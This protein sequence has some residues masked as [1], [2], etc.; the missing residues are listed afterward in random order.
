MTTKI[1]LIR[2]AEAEGNWRRTFQGH[3][4]GEISEKGRRQLE[5]LAERFRDIPL[6]AV[7]SSPLRR[8]VATAQAVNH[9]GLPII[10][11]DRLM[12]INGG[13][14]EGLRF[15]ELSEHFPSEHENWRLAPHLFTAPNGE[16]MASVYARMREVMGEIARNNA[17]KT[18][19][20]A[21]HGCAIRNYQCFALGLGLP[22]IGEVTWCDNTA[23]TLLEYGEDFT[24]R[25]VALGDSSHLPES[26]STL[27][28]QSWWRTTPERDAHEKGA[29]I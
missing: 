13:G 2:H 3:S 23:V 8:A 18:V 5:L 25:V 19:A 15:D 17:G 1:Y 10:T 6:D 21:S 9:A 20:V 22:R 14:F 26:E 27:A 24:P 12:E 4:N 7:Y 28:T 16:S 11:D 29:A